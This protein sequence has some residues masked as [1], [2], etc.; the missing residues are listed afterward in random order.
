MAWWVQ[1]HYPNHLSQRTEVYVPHEHVTT[2]ACYP[3]ER[4]LYSGSED[5]YLQVY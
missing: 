5:G 3:N 1:Y 4:M 2:I